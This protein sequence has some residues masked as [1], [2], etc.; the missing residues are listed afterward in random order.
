MSPTVGKR[1]NPQLTFGV[2]E[3]RISSKADAASS[4]WGHWPRKSLLTPRQRRRVVVASRPLSFVVN[5]R[6]R[7]CCSLH[8]SS[9]LCPPE[10]ARHDGV[11]GNRSEKPTLSI[12]YHAVP[13]K[14]K[15][16][17]KM[18]CRRRRSNPGQG[19]PARCSATPVTL[20]EC[21]RRKKEIRAEKRGKEI[22][23]C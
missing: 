23:R 9:V 18:L 4:S 13:D 10:E 5:G 15:R 19:T 11:S 8:T 14:K 16:S 1:E 21:E 3:R 7:V 17:R 2:G 20:R 12:M 6:R 22:V